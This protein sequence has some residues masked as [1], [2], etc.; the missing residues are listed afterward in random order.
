MVGGEIHLSQ[1][2]P[3]VE[4]RTAHIPGDHL[5]RAIPEPPIRMEHYPQFEFLE[6]RPKTL[7]LKIEGVLILW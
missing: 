1:Y 3:Q 5:S 4:G 2:S 7:S 6:L